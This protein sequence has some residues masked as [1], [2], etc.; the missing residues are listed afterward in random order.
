ME[1]SF[2]F[3]PL[4]SGYMAT[5]IIGF[6]VS[7]MYVYNFNEGSKP[8]GVAFAIVFAAMFLASVGSMTQADA[9]AYIKTETW[10]K[11]KKK[12]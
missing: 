1:K 9:N 7:I 3:A 6:F 5:S 10:H 11:K 12:A 4:S 2:R 8:W